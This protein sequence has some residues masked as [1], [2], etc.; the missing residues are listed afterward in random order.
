LQANLFQ[1]FHPM[2]GVG[3]RPGG[4]ISGKSS[5]VS[6]GGPLL[7]PP[8]AAAVV[9]KPMKSKESLRMRRDYVLRGGA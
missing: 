6:G 7:P 3:A 4:G 5:S 2:G 8:H 9:I 1:L